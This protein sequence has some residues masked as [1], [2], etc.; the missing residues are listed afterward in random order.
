MITENIDFTPPDI[1]GVACKSV[2][3]PCVDYILIK[4]VAFGKSGFDLT[5]E[6]QILVNFTL[7]HERRY[8]PEEF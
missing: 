2:Y 4:E 8:K 7:V 1:Q 3:M 6:K 5:I